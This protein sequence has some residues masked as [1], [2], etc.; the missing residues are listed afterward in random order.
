MKFFV[1]EFQHW[2]ILIFPDENS[3][4]YGINTF[5]YHVNHQN[6]QIIYSPI[7]CMNHNSNIGRHRYSN[8]Q[9]SSLLIPQRCQTKIKGLIIT[10]APINILSQYPSMGGQVGNIGDLTR[11]C[12][13]Y[14]GQLSNLQFPWL[15]PLQG[16][17][18]DRCTTAPS[19]PKFP[20]NAL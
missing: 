17:D 20:K 12:S 13:I 4:L 10:Y 14:I 18:I 6:Q 2:K 9:S 3:P 5:L 15:S 16:Q 19:T 1:K 11:Q 8:C 7:P